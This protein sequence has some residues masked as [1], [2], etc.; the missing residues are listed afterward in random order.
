MKKIYRAVIEYNNCDSCEW[1]RWT[2]QTSAWYS[3]RALAEQHLRTMWEFRDYA[4]QKNADEYHFACN[5]PRIEESYVADEF[6]PLQLNLNG[7]PFER[8]E[9]EPYTG[10]F[11]I[12]SKEFKSEFGWD[13][14]LKV[15]NEPIQLHF[16][17][18]YNDDGTTEVKHFAIYEKDL[19]RFEPTVRLSIENI[20]ANFEKEI[21]PYYEKYAKEEDEL[22]NKMDEF[23]FGSEERVRAW[24]D[25]RCREI[26]VLPEVLDK[27]EMKLSKRGREN[28]EWL[29]GQ[30]SKFPKYKQ[31]LENL[32]SKY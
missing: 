8:V 26:E 20:A 21:L 28:F 13:I 22:S 24:S 4:M 3:D 30:S 19:Y 9:Y 1:E 23:E 17:K 14:Y 16:T 12:T 15:D 2:T 29:L 5:E 31:L 6:E 25:W 18:I 27:F 7:K 32:L 10:K 11:E